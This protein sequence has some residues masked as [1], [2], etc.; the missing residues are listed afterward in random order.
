MVIYCNRLQLID[1]FYTVI[2]NK[3]ALLGLLLA[4]L[5]PVHLFQMMWRWFFG[6]ERDPIVNVTFG[7]DNNSFKMYAPKN[8]Q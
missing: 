5:Q 8:P 1:I 2:A 3:M 7:E 6:P 4:I